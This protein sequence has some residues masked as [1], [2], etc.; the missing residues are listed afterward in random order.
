MRNKIADVVAKSYD[1]KITRTSS[2]RDLSKSITPM[3]TKHT[4]EIYQYICIY[5]YH[6]KKGNNLSMK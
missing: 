1:G 4:C 6:L 3:Q 5:I 2:Q